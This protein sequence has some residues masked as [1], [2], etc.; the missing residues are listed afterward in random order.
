MRDCRFKKKLLAK[1][2]TNQPKYVC[3]VT[4][5]N[6]I[7]EIRIFPLMNCK[8]L[9]IVLI[10]FFQYKL[11]QGNDMSLLLKMETK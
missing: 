8:K 10:D 2:R 11:E 3:A 9:K 1:P 4:D 6:K 5:L 7:K